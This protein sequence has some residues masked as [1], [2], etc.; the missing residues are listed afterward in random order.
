MSS[1]N[2]SRPTLE[3]VAR[4]AGVSKATASK[5][6]NRR[7]DIS[8]QTRRRVEQAIDELGYVP[9][10]GPREKDRL[11]KVN[12]VF[13]TLVNV[14]SM[15]VLDGILTA[16]H[17]QDVEVLVDKLDP[18]PEGDGPLSG[19]WIRR[20]AAHGRTGVIVVTSELTADQ[21]DLMRSLGLSVVMI[22]PLNPL[23]DEVVSVGATNFTGGMQATRHLLD[24][25]HRRIAFAGGLPISM[26]SRERLQGYLSA[27]SSAGVALDPSLVLEQGFS[28]LAG[29]E[30]ASEFLAGPQPPTAIFAGCD[31]SALGVLEAARR[32]SLR[33]P[34]DL[35]V[36]GF[37]DTYVAVS[38]APPLTTVRQPIIDMGRVA[39]R[40]LLQQARGERADSHHV[41]LS[42][43]LVVRESTA[44][45]AAAP[46]GA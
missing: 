15:Q 10:T 27:M 42:T 11:Q 13:D 45:P 20:L 41:Q 3:Q 26:A 7:P 8:A 1:T 5:V 43:Q 36:V 29:L 4:V 25:G 9:T 23:D 17:S 37:D 2:A 33:V 28:F 35:S 39:L 18:D 40:T 31:A 6:L 22:D 30:M 34:Q 44:A 24:L 46:V 21:R 32:R 14:Y 19:G 12:V 38:T 16:A